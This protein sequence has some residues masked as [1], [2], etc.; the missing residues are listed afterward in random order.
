MIHLF[1]GKVRDVLADDVQGLLIGVGELNGHTHHHLPMNL[2]TIAQALGQ[3]IVLQADI[4]EFDGILVIA[5]VFHA[6][7]VF[8]QSYV[9]ELKGVVNIHGSLLVTN[10]RKSPAPGRGAGECLQRDYFAK[11]CST[12]PMPKPMKLPIAAPRTPIRTP[13]PAKLGL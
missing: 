11:S 7:D 2:Q 4:D 9:L 5:V 1:F 3:V 6:Q 8:R 13:M 10:D 12:A